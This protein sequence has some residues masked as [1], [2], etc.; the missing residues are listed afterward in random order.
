MFEYAR[1]QLTKFGYEETFTGVKPEKVSTFI[2]EFNEESLKKSIFN[3]EE[4]E[5]ITS[6][7]INY[8]ALLLRKKTE[9]YPE[10]RTS[11]RFKRFLRKKVT[12]IDKTAKPGEEH[13]PKW[14]LIIN[15][16]CYY[17]QK[18]VEE[19]FTQGVTQL[20]QAR[21]EC[22]PDVHINLTYCCLHVRYHK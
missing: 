13:K 7:F 3:S 1:D 14:L 10:G 21:L 9:K 6:I 8:P 12:I 19:Q 11:Y 22:L 18:L 17:S 16:K 4:S 20:D 5:E 15:K 2:D